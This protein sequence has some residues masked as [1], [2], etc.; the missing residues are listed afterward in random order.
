MESFRSRCAQATALGPADPE[1]SPYVGTTKMCSSFLQKSTQGVVTPNHLQFAAQCCIAFY[2]HQLHPKHLLVFSHAFPHKND[3]LLSLTLWGQV[4]LPQP[5]NPALPLQT[6]SYV[7]R[8]MEATECNHVWSSAFIM[9]FTVYRDVRFQF[10][11]RGSQLMLT[12]LQIIAEGALTHFSY[13]NYFCS[14][15]VCSLTQ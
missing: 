14:F 3:F 7:F 13:E 2:K 12:S 15:L 9:T 11:D 10:R 8:D 5:T 6:P 4:C 1:L